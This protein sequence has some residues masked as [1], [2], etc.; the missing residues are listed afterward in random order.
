[1]RRWIASSM[2]PLELPPDRKLEIA[3]N[4]NSEELGDVVTDAIHA[5]RMPFPTGSDLEYVWDGSVAGC[6]QSCRAGEICHVAQ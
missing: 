6:H 5:A 4:L 2:L 1:M 3:S